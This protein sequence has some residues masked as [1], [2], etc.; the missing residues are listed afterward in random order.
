MLQLGSYKIESEKQEVA[1]PKIF[2]VYQFGDM[3]FYKHDSE[4]FLKKFCN[5][6]NIPWAYTYYSYLGEEV[7]KRSIS[8]QEDEENIRRNRK[9]SKWVSK[10]REVAH[11]SFIQE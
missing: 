1:K 8:L 2:G 7:Y 10:P 4:G 11:E 5:Q 6:H 9:A 3:S